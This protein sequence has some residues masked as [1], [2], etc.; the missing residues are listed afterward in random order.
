MA[1]CGPQARLA[2][3]QAS[4]G[5]ASG[6]SNRRKTYDVDCSYGS[7]R[8]R[9][10]TPSGGMWGGILKGLTEGMAGK[11]AY[12]GVMDSCLAQYGWSG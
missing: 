3:S 4:A 9:D 12:D 10:V 2:K 1:I 5:A 6:S 11:R 7:C 8:A